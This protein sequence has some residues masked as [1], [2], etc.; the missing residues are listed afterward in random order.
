MMY[1]VKDHN[2]LLRD[3]SNQA[4]INVDREKLSEH[5]N[6]KQMKDN[7]EY[8]NEEIASLKSDF[9]EIK[10]LLQQIASRG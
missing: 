4:I 7:I 3:P 6:K 2:N 9:Q 10:F 1:K 8:L 5:R